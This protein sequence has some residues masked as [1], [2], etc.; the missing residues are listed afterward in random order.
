MTKK[1]ISF[2][3]VSFLVLLMFTVCTK[4]PPIKVIDNIAPKTYL[5]NVPLQVDTTTYDST[6]YIYHAR[7]LFWYGTDEDGI[8]TRFD[9]AID[10]T[11]YNDNIP[12]SGW[13]SLYMDSTL[14]TQDTIAFAAPLPDTIYSHTFYVRAV[15]NKDLPDATPASRVF[16]TSNITPNTRFVS[17]PKDS[18]QRF[19]LSDTTA[20][21]KGI[22]FEWTAIDSDEVFPCQFQYIW[23]DVMPAFDDPGWSDPFS[24]ESYYFTGQNAPMD[25]GYHTLYIRAFD[26]AGAVDPSLSDT[27]IFITEIDTT[28]TPPDTTWDT[29]VYNQWVTIYFVTPEIAENPNYRK[30]LWIN[31]ATS[32][33]NWMCIKPFYHTILEDSLQM[34]FDS[35]DY[36]F[37]PVDHRMFGGYSTIMWSKDDA[38]SWPEFPLDSLKDLIAD[39]LHVG[40]RIIFAGSKILNMGQEFAEKT[41]FAVRKSFPF[42]ELHISQY[43]NI[44]VGSLEDTIL[45]PAPSDTAFFSQE[46][47]YPHLSLNNNTT[48][49][50]AAWWQLV[51]GWL[52]IEVL[53]LDLWGDYGGDLNI[54]YTMNHYQN[55]ADYERQPCATRYTYEGKTTPAFFYFGFPLAYMEYGKATQ[56]LRNVFTELKEIP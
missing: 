10:D 2:I 8:V 45:P 24:E 19:I 46:G 32:A 34:S 17:T 1:V 43:I 11:S 35:L 12:G 37:E 48:Y 21:W 55:H 3:F 25:E 6:T 44:G 54:M 29:T 33:A 49:P 27:T 40:G 50:D 4:K 20:N 36:G 18:S 28:V 38:T 31:F 22:N 53:S 5:C 7:V 26:D 13:H 42:T 56:L 51:G 41:S 47:Q 16:N 23:S 39:Y 30:I 52:I 15:D 9:W 14:A